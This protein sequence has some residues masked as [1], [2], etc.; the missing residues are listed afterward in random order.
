L[1]STAF[2]GISAEERKYIAR[3]GIFEA[4][5]V[6]DGMILEG[7]TSNFFY[8]GRNAIA[9]YL[10]TAQ[11]EILLGVTRQIIIEIAQN[12]RLEV[13]YQ[14]LK[15]DQLATASEAFIT[16]SSRGV[17]PVI[18]ID[19]VTIGQGTPGPITKKLSAIYDIYVT[20]KAEKIES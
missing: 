14:P 4:L 10:G 17:V 12:N 5:L 18:Q 6:K 7:M 8:A 15:R 9:P 13:K 2:I 20:K 19:Q 1:K 16:S 11:D 3:E